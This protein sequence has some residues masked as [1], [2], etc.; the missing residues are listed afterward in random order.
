MFDN[1]TRTSPNFNKFIQE[2]SA[3]LNGRTFTN[4]DFVKLAE[5]Y[6]GASLTNF[7]DQWLYGFNM[8]QFNVEYSF[9]QRDESFY[10]DGSVITKNVGSGFSMPVIMRIELEGSTSEESVYLRETVKAPESLFSLGPF[11]SEPKK[12]VFNEFFSVLSQDNVKK[13]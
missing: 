1:K 8:P 7:F 10:V 2:L 3:T 6:Y 13:K 9:V 5:K 12:F 11:P 4:A